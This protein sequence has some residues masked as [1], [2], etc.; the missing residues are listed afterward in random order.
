MRW[1]GLT[2][3]MGTG[4]SRVA[5]LF[6]N[7]GVPVIDADQ[8]SRHLT[9]V[10]SEAISEIRQAFGPDVVLP[11]G[12]LNRKHLGELVF[13]EPNKLSQLEK[14]LHPRI[15]KAVQQK[16][17]DLQHQGHAFAVYDVPLL[18]EK[19]LEEQFDLIIV[20]TADHALQIQRV[21]N[22]DGLS[23][24]EIERRLKA[25]LP[26]AEKVAKADYVIDN[27]GTLEQLEAQVRNLI[28]ELTKP[29]NNPV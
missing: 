28:T 21:Q 5:Q 16:R 2:G 22:R 26:L 19:K 6:Q 20:V 15:Q 3:G 7:A 13:R 24:S 18:Y 27:N 14:I 11:D 1:V 10:G 17:A 25:Q 4:K 12:G 29:K 9:Q 8:I 23:V